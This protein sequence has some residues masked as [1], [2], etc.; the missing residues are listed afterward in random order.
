MVDTPNPALA[1]LSPPQP[2]E[3]SGPARALASLFAGNRRFAEGRAH[4]GYL[5]SPAARSS[6]QK[7]YALVVG[8]LD[9][10]VI[11][12]AVFDQDFGSIMV[13]RVGGHVIDSAVLGSVDFAVSTLEVPLVL[14]LGHQ[15]CGAVITSAQ[16][17]RDGV[18]PAGPVGY[19]VEQIAPAVDDVLASHGADDPGLV[20]KVTCRHVARTVEA[21][22]AVP[23]VTRRI[24]AGTLQVVGARYDV[25]TAL[26]QL[27][28]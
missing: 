1:D 2:A 21:L 7:P 25:D 27:L 8:C 12:E 13:V 19:L 22:S 16:A 4:H 14:V 5:H 6:V 15:Y 10:R 3:L 11:P 28:D 18:R 26:V 23:V 24:E 20:E 9:S 17:V